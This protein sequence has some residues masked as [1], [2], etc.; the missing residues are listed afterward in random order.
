MQLVFIVGNIST[1]LELAA[2]FCFG[3]T[4]YI[5]TATTDY[6][7]RKHRTAAAALEIT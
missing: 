7:I 4:S 5:P 2:P 3:V 6:A 1:E